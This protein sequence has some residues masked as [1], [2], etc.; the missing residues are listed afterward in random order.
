MLGICYMYI[1]EIIIEDNKNSKIY[2]FLHFITR[3]TVSF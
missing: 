3:E 2:T 1:G